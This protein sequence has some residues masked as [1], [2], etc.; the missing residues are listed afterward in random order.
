MT[1]PHSVLYHAISKLLRPLVRVLLKQGISHAEFTELSKKAF[2]DVA[3][4]DF[5]I[6]GKKQTVSRVAILTGLNRKEV[7]RLKN[8]PEIVEQTNSHNRAVR[9]TSGWVRDKEFLTAKGYPMQ[10]PIE[11]E[12]NS[13][14]SLVKK[15]SGDMP[16]RAMLDEL[17]RVGSVERRG[18]KLKLCSRGYIPQGSEEEKIRLMG[19][20]VYDLLNTLDYNIEHSLKESKLQLAV[21]YDNLPKSVLGEFKEFSKKE[22][23]A[24][25]V[26]LDKWLAQ[27]DR[28]TSGDGD[29]NDSDPRVRA[30]IGVYYFEED[31]SAKHPSDDG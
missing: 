31:F 3:E 10:L 12:L 17:E 4:K 21:A 20:S 11:G 7:Q 18:D 24:L 2:V 5:V 8:L 19:Q 13:F 6:K 9:V 15:Y 16:V 30:G 22:V 25:L 26:H 27:R 28:D 29:Q 23:Q 14:S 1:K